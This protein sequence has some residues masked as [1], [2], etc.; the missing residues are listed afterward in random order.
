MP[1]ALAEPEAA[2]ASSP[3]PDPPSFE[4][5]KFSFTVTAGDKPRDHEAEVR[6]LT[7]WLMARWEAQPRKEQRVGNQSAC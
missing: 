5:G 7:N 3:D 1:T 2:T 6:A 4:V